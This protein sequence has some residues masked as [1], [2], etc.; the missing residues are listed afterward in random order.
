VIVD[1]RAGAILGAKQ[2]STS[3]RESAACAQAI[4]AGVTGL[5]PTAKTNASLPKIEALSHGLSQNSGVG[6][7]LRE[8]VAAWSSLA[9]PLKAAI[10]AIVR[11]VK[12]V[13]PNNFPETTPPV[14]GER[15]NPAE[16]KEG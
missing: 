10:L 7:D 11:A 14:S 3:R 13:T 8:V 9:E 6:S 4:L 12:G 1:G 5:E 2:K 15:T 16:K